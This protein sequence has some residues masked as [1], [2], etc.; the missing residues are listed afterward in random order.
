MKNFIYILC[1][2]TFVVVI[3]LLAYRE[4][5]M[6]NMYNESF[7]NKKTLKSKQKHVIFFGD[8]ILENSNYVEYDKTVESV[9]TNPKKYGY[10]VENF[11]EDDAII[12]DINDQFND[13]FATNRISASMKRKIRDNGM[14]IISVGG[15]DLL[16]KYHTNKNNVKDMSYF[17]NI[18]GKYKEM[19]KK[20]EKNLKTN[21]DGKYENIKIG[22]IGLYFPF[23]K[24]Y[25]NYDKIVEKW[26][27][28]LKNLSL[29]NKNMEYIDLSI[30][31]NNKNHFV[32]DIE[33]SSKGSEIIAKQINLTHKKV[34]NSN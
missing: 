15:N 18:W 3:G 27:K 17:D 13:F 24:K 7:K 19:I 22:L 29:K 9:L 26:N 25:K 21:V 31:F 1:I 23:D 28:N 14:I 16:N 5:Y 10:V 12:N 11:A 32:D 33:P 6:K 30:V 4:L 2:L 8:S 20:M 34:I